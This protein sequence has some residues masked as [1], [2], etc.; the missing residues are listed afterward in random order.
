MVVVRFGTRVG[1]PAELPAPFRIEKRLRA[2]AFDGL[3]PRV[4][5]RT[6]EACRF[7]GAKAVRIG[8]LLRAIAPGRLPR[9]TERRASCWGGPPVWLKVRLGVNDPRPGRRLVGPETCHLLGAPLKLRPL[10]KTV[11]R[12]SALGDWNA[13]PFI[14]FVRLAWDIPLKR[15]AL[16]GRNALFRVQT[17]FAANWELL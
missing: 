5:R 3:P 15:V 13:P 4:G 2:T 12:G 17:L 16:R 6:T 9:T 14:K 11:P 8:P 1:R 10:R 7:V